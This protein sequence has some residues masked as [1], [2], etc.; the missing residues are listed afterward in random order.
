MMEKDSVCADEIKLTSPVSRFLLLE[1]EKIMLEWE[2]LVR[3]EIKGAEDTAQPILIDTLPLFL[4]NLAQALDAHHPRAL[5]TDSSTVAKEHGGERARVTD[6]TPAMILQEYQIL[7]E[8]IF[9]KLEAHNFYNRVI[10]TVIHKSFDQ[11]VQESMTAYF[12]VHKN[13]N[14]QFVATLTHDLRNP[15]GAAKLSTDLLMRKLSA[16][17]TENEFEKLKDLAA[18]A[19][20]NL[21]RTDRMIQYL[22]DSNQVQSGKKLQLTLKDSNL[23]LILREILQDLPSS[24]RDRINLLSENV[25]ILADAPLIRRAVENLISNAFK[26][27]AFDTP[28]S[29]KLSSVLGRALISVHN[30]GTAIPFKEQQKIFDLSHRT[31]S[32][33]DGEARGWGLGLAFVRAVCEAH[34]GSVSIDSASE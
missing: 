4:S 30:E 20:R 2:R 21:F 31:Q 18:R 3:K 9:E 22:L 14:D 27:G 8:I 29:I 13:L 17:V 28:V 24:N 33:V 1:T 7:R 23:A 25:Q 19:S 32:A 11:A 12:T 34:G 10:F 5:A 26:Y 16:P 6:F 15:I